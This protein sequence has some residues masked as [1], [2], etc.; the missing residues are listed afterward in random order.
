MS[1]QQSFAVSHLARRPSDNIQGLHH[2]AQEA[3]MLTSWRSSFV[4]N[5][6]PFAWRPQPDLSHERVASLSSAGPPLCRSTPSRPRRRQ[7][8]PEEIEAERRRSQRLQEAFRRLRRCL[9]PPRATEGRRSK[10]AVIR[11]AAAY[12]AELRSHLQEL[13]TMRERSSEVS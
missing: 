6:A 3:A 1:D 4:S 7:R 13:D 11:M 2:I 10:A 8:R 5:A 12:I 9:P